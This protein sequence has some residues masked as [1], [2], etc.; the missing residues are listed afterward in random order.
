MCEKMCYNPNLDLVNINAYT[1]FAEILL[2]WY[3]DIERKSNYDGRND[4]QPNSS[5]A[6][7]FQTRATTK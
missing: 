7:P 2:M 3:Q 1:E 6:P 4:R 5:I